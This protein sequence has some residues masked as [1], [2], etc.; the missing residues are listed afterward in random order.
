MGDNFKTVLNSFKATNMPKMYISSANAFTT[1]KDV[2][3]Y[4]EYKNEQCEEL[5]LEPFY[6]LGENKEQ[7]EE[8]VEKFISECKNKYK[9]T[10]KAFS[11]SLGNCQLTR[12]PGDS[13]IY[14][15][16]P[17]GV[18]DAIKD[19]LLYLNGDIGGIKE[20]YDDSKVIN[21]ENYQ[22]EHKAEINPEATSGNE[23][24][25]END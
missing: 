3:K 16:K 11:K 24:T 6:V 2:I 14:E 8:D 20:Y 18:T 9:T 15:H 5:G 13:K 1:E 4:Y 21:W 19:F 22:E 17:E 10:T 12:I 7:V 25:K 23:D